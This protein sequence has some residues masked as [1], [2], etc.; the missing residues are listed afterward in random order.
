MSDPYR[1]LNLP[2]SADQ[3]AI[4]QAYRKLAKSLHPDR[5]PGNA[6]GRAA[7]QGGHAGLR[8]A[9][10][11]GQARPLRSRRDRR[12]GPAARLRRLRGGF[13]E[14]SR[15]AGGGAGEG[16]FEKMFG[17]AF[18][19][20]F[21]GGAGGGRRA[22]AFEEF[23]ARPVERPAAAARRRPPLPAR[24]RL[25][26]R[27]ARQPAA[28]AAGRR[29]H[30]RGRRAG[31]HRE[32]QA[33]APQGTGRPSALDGPA[34]D[35]LVEIQVRPH[36]QLSREGRDIHVEVPLALADAVLGT[37][38]TVPTLDGSVRLTVPPGASSGAH[39]ASQGQGHR[40]AGR[41][42]GDQYVRL[43]V[44]LPERPDRELEAWARRHARGAEG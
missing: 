40:R 43:L 32:R 10:R 2:R 6:A 27:R 19:R 8:P 3:A 26:R 42:R 20:G 34:G 22:A 11:S 37:R 21:A 30:D 12:R 28:A 15:A 35:A 1:L 36:P 13:G 9:V 16:L 31:R 14:A 44:V 41:R 38:I 17:G 18:A 24:G 23:A 5:N 29:P 7:L 39:A 25:R 33:A 4:K